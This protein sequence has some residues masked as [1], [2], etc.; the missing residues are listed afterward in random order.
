M[1]VVQSDK[2]VELLRNVH[3]P[4]TRTR[5]ESAQVLEMNSRKRGEGAGDGILP[6][7]HDKQ[8]DNEVAPACVK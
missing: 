7:G 5:Q 4:A 6:E 1:V 8:L 3:V 2:D